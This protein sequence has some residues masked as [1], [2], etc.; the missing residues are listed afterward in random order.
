MSLAVCI[1]LIYWCFHL[2]LFNSRVIYPAGYI[3]VKRKY[4]SKRI[5]GE[6][7]DDTS[8]VPDLGITEVHNFSTDLQI[9]PQL[10]RE[11]EGW[12]PCSSSPTAS[13]CLLHWFSRSSALKETQGRLEDSTLQ[14]SFLFVSHFHCWSP[15]FLNK[16]GKTL[17][18]NL[19]R[20]TNTFCFP[21]EAKVCLWMERST[22]VF[23]SSPIPASTSE[24]IR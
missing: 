14:T 17:L 1:C 9:C 5:I 23:L 4:V 13:S 3:Q 19:K 18:F 10:R 22:S 21:S 2:M 16:G 11:T 8:N 6:F 24:A 12:P 20:G 7:F 15:P